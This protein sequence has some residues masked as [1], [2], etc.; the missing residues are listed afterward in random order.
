MRRV[1]ATCL[2]ALS[3]MSGTWSPAAAGDVPASLPIVTLVDVPSTV[4]AGTQ[5]SIGAMVPRGTRCRLVVRDSGT[6]VWRGPRA[7]ARTS[8]MQFPWTQQSGAAVG[9]WRARVKCLT[10]AG[11]A[12]SARGQFVVTTRVADPISVPALTAPTS[13]AMSVVPAAAGWAPFGTT[14]IKGTDWYQGRGVDVVSNGGNGCASGCAVRGAYGTKYQCVELV[15]RFVR[16]QNWVTANIMGNARD[17]LAKAPGAVFDKHLAG[18]GYQPV[19]GDII[20]WTGGSSGYGHVA[21]VSSV[22]PK[23]VIFVEQNASR[24]GSYTLKISATGRLA[25]YGWLSHQGYLHAKVNVG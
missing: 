17:I 20:T 13:A 3:V 14:L 22:G 2:T 16:T 23:G 8:Y 10:A 25:N 18:D 24:T 4:H 11:I 9:T 6:Q 15:N 21:V 5:S 1:A 7:V 12:R 19:P